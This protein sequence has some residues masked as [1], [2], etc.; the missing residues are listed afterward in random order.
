MAT[1]SDKTIDTVL[2]ELVPVKQ[3]AE[4]AGCSRAHLSELLNSGRASGRKVA[5]RWFVFRH[6]IPDLRSALTSRSAGKK[7]LAVRPAKSR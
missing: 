7:H 5:G 2:E 6:T 3:A 1:T 4:E